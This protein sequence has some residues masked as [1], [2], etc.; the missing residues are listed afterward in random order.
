M[1]LTILFKHSNLSVA[2]SPMNLTRNRETEKEIKKQK[3]KQT[4]SKTN[5]TDQLQILNLTTSIRYTHQTDHRTLLL[6]SIP[7]L[8]TLDSQFPKTLIFILGLPIFS[9]LRTT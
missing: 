8:R 5:Q 7:I 9:S 1:N 6:T 2:R 4:Q 3:R